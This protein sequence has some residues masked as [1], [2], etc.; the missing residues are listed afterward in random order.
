[1]A[2]A[3]TSVRGVRSYRKN[4]STIDIIPLSGDKANYSGIAETFRNTVFENSETKC[5]DKIE[6]ID[7]V[8]R[9]VLKKK[10][11]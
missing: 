8:K 5:K 3:R 4:L 2:P 1:M 9:S 6:K 10:D 11:Y 7:K